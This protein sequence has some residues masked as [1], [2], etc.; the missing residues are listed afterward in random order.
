MPQSDFQLPARPPQT[1]GLPN[2]PDSIKFEGFDGINTKTSRVAI[3]DTEARWMDN[4]MPVGPSNARALPDVGPAVYSANTGGG[5]AQ[6]QFANFGNVPVSI[7]FESGGSITQINTSSGAVSTVAPAGTITDP[8]QPIGFAQWGSEYALI[9]NAQPNGY[10][11]WDGTSFYRA[12]TLGPAVDISREGAGY[13]S[14]P[15]MTV[16]GGAGNAASLSASVQG[17]AVTRLTVLAAGSGW[18]DGDAAVVLFSGGGSFGTSARAT[19]TINS[20][21][22][23]TLVTVLSADCGRGY[24]AASVKANFL[25]GG[26]GFGAA[27][28]VALSGTCINTVAV[29][30]GGGGY[31]RPP[32]VHFTDVNSA[33][34]QATIPLMP[35]G[36]NGTS[37]ETYT[38]RVWLTNGLDPAAAVKSRILFTAPSAPSD[39]SSTNGGGSATGTNS[40]LRVG[41]N[42]LKQS[43]GFLY[44][45]G[46]SSLDYVSG[47]TTTGTPPA[48]TFNNQNIDPQ[49]GTPWQETVKVFSRA[50]VFANSY[51]VHALYGGAV[52]K[53]S[54]ALDGV[55]ATVSGAAFGITPSAAVAT[56]FGIQVY[57]MLYPVV[58]PVSGI[59]RNAVFMWDG[60]KWWTANPS[61]SLTKIAAQEVDSVLTAWGTDGRSLY[62]LFQR[63]SNMTTKTIQSRLYSHPTYIMQK[64]T[65]YVAG[66]VQSMG[67]EN[68]SFRITIE[69]EQAA[70][71]V[72]VTD[73]STVTWKTNSGAIVTW[74]TASGNAT[75]WTRPRLGYFLTPVDVYGQLIGKTIRSTT[76]DFVINSFTTMI[77]QDSL[78]I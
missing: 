43:N 31:I 27:A 33:V 15:T 37:V 28:T 62:R 47:V 64:R 30:S 50:V 53:V 57:C 9:A 19:A 21:G 14:A 36:I 76:P 68:A 17:G 11:I 26:G 42:A 48:T 34:A 51:G 56:V 60:G 6:V 54:G 77:T 35:F 61:V 20:D 18:L 1:P 66:L 69:S 59:Q 49:V 4:I 63:A 24:A 70:Q 16:F 78:K 65:K 73:E 7:V 74:T 8:S 58:D 23:V 13:S 52:Q 2:N 71:T 41:Y 40:F 39:F 44:I 3:K 72:S 32:T 55:Y 75:T 67:V 46:D 25:G 12:G 10:F 38:G 22:A 45:F 29:T 5:I